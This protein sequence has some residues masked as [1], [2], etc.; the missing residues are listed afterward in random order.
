MENGTY[1]ALLV[2]QERYEAR[3]KWSTANFRHYG[4]FLGTLK[5]QNQGLAIHFAFF[6]VVLWH[7]DGLIRYSHSLTAT[8][9]KNI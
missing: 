1:V 4:D 6:S 9:F 8:A 7:C 2:K 5:H 3:K